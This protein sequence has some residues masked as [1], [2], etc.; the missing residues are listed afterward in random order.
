MALTGR[1]QG[2]GDQSSRDDNRPWR[3]HVGNSS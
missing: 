1:D 3:V 2:A